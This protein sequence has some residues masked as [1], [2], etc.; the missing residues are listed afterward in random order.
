M[1]P[2]GAGDPAWFEV[3]LGGWVA[4]S[5]QSPLNGLITGVAGAPGAVGG[6]ALGALLLRGLVVRAPRSAPV[7][8][9]SPG[10]LSCE[11]HR[12]ELLAP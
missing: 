1:K 8:T 3:T 4:G 5:F 11:A 9:A 10:H 6:G 2:D 7:E 12:C